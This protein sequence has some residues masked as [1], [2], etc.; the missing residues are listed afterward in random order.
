MKTSTRILSLASMAIVVVTAGAQ[1]PDTPPTIKWDPSEVAVI[2]ASDQEK[3]FEVFRDSQGNPAN[4]WTLPV[5]GQQC[6]ISDD[7]CGDGAAVRIDNLDFLPLQFQATVDIS[8]Y[9]FFHLDLWAQNDDQICIKFQ[10]WWP[11]ESFVTEIF[12]LKGGEWKSIDID[13]DRADF[14]WEK[15]NEIPQHCVNI[16]QLGGEA[17]PND[18]PHSPAIYLTN[19]MAHNDA[20]VLGGAGVGNVVVENAPAD[21]AVYNLFCQ[22]VDKSYKGIV[23]SKGRK[24]IQK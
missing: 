13:L 21:D 23:V 7:E 1:T 24:F 12:D 10:N 19:I 22:R 5:W 3:F 2:Y 11:G 9:R 14:T 4:A 15:K 8:D 18:Y 17:L 16:L 20:S 6:V